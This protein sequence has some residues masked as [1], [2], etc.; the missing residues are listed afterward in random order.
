VYFWRRANWGVVSIRGYL[1]L[2]E[3]VAY[4]GNER[5]DQERA[6]QH[7]GYDRRCNECLG[8]VCNEVLG[9]QGC[10]PWVCR[11]LLVVNIE[12]MCRTS[13]NSN[14]EDDDQ[15]VDSDLRHV[16]RSRVDLH[17]ADLFLVVYTRSGCCVMIV[18][19]QVLS[20]RTTQ[21]VF[22]ERLE[23]KQRNKVQDMYGLGVFAWMSWMLYGGDVHGFKTHLES[24]KRCGLP[25][26][27]LSIRRH[28][29][30]GQ[31]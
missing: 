11:P 13:Q 12:C 19:C 9:P 7:R 10:P 5:H 15:T 24:F 23:T 8:A 2:V 31:E 16:K 4:L 1:G 21:R 29:Y 27:T 20:T 30:L 18:Q 22:N 17:L 25:A 6:Q 26:P 28:A 3:V 14:A